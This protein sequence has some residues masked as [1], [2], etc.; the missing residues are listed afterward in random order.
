MS[1]YGCNNFEPSYASTAVSYRELKDVHAR[2]R[3][4]PLTTQYETKLVRDMR[5]EKKRNLICAFSFSVASRSTQVLT[6]FTVEV[7]IFIFD[8]IRLFLFDGVVEQPF[9]DLAACLSF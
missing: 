2:Q 1:S 5:I 3:E 8:L 6:K 4:R 7:V 9:M